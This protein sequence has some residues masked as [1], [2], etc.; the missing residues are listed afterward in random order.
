MTQELTVDTVIAII[1]AISFTLTALYVLIAR[2]YKSSWKPGFVILCTLAEVTLAHVFKNI[3]PDLKVRIFWYKMVFAGFNIAPTAFLCYTLHYTDTIHKFTAVKRLLLMLFP[4][5]TITAIFT[6]EMHSLMWKPD[7]IAQITYSIDF[8]AIPDAGIW[9]WLFI[10]YTFI[11]MGISSSILIRYLAHQRGAYNRQ[12]VAIIAAVIIVML[13]VALGLIRLSSLRQFSITTLALT[14]CSITVV[15]SLSPLRRRDLLSVTHSTIFRSINVGIITVNAEIV[16]LDLNPAAEKLAGKSAAQVIGKPLEKIIPELAFIRDGKTDYDSTLILKHGNDRHTYNLVISSI[17]DWQ[18]AVAGCVI[19][20]DNITR[21]MQV[22]TAL[23]AQREA[24]QFFSKQ[25]TILSETMN[26]LSKTPTL[27]E[28]CR[29]AVEFG[30]NRLGFDRISLWFF[31]DDYSIMLG[32][33]G[34]DASG[35]TTNEHDNR[36]TVYPSTR[37]WSLI[38]RETALLHHKN[39]PL[40]QGGNQI[41]YGERLAAGLWDGEKVTGYLSVDNLIRQRPFSEHDCELLR[42]YASGLGHLCSLKRAQEKLA[43][44][45]HTLEQRVTERT[46][47]LERANKELEAFTY[48]V[49]HDL[50]AP[51]RAIDGYSGILM[52]DYRSSLDSEGIRICSVVKD[53]AQRMNELI[54][55]LLALSRFSRAGIQT[56]LVDMA[57]LAASVFRELVSPADGSRID[58]RIDLLPDATADFSLIRQVWVN[59]ISNAVKFSS[60]RKQALIRVTAAAAVGGITYAVHDNG[61]GFDMQYYDKLFGVFQRLHSD[62]EFPGTGVGLAIVQR[63]IHRHGGRIWAESSMGNGAAFYFTLPQTGVES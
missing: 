28:L 52:E 6:N 44:L 14:A 7:H 59:L 2:R 45:T 63:I 38:R 25:L 54:N 43:R 58:F 50:R 36:L 20:L 42:L 32:T 55:D 47:E 5:L 35:N 29:C 22:E 31:K 4:A 61:V 15:F 56:S 48:S 46:A 12:V 9:Y 21:R 39:S 40:Y 24:E 51:L 17:L 57:E 19:T 1:A 26:E 16:I 13:G 11:I 53:E 18:G 33:Y 62:R 34:T 10:V 37:L 8:L 23:I 30:R 3:S 27:D 60:N 41:G 49:S